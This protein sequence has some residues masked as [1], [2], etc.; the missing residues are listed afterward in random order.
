MEERLQRLNAAGRG[1]NPNDDRF[2][3]ISTRLLRAIWFN[4][5]GHFASTNNDIEPPICLVGKD[6]A[7][8]SGRAEQRFRAAIVSWVQWSLRMS[9]RDILA[10]GTSA[11]GVEALRFLAS[12]F[13][14]DFPASVLVVIHLSAHYE[15]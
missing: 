7:A 1:A 6:F 15:S 2:G 8:G 12:E 11:G 14:N 13:P 3:A 4:V 10:I 9:H 5:F